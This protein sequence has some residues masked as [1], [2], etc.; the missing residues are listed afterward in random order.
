MAMITVD[1]LD[2]TGNRREPVTLP[3]DVPVNRIMVMLVEKMGLP[4]RHALDNRLLVYKFHHASAGQIRDEQTLA[5]AG[6]REGD[7]LRLFGEM[8]AGSR[9]FA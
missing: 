2:A 7:V 5:G 6:V 3:D 1:V 4:T 8:I 9:S